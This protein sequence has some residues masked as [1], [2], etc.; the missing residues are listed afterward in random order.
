MLRIAIVGTGIIGLSHIN[1]I[2]SLDNCRLCALCDINED[3]V[4]KLAEE[5]GVP[6]FLNYKDIPGSVEC[7]A[8]IINL[9]HGL[10]CESSIFFLENGIHVLVEKPMANTTEECDKMIEAANKAGKKIAVA[11]VQRYFDTNI[12]LKNIVDSG[13]LGKLAMISEQ[14]SIN[15][16]LDSRP[17]WFL[18]KKAAGGGI[19]M[20]YGAHALDKVQFITGS[21]V[22]EI[23]GS[24]F[25][26]KND[27][28]IEGNAQ[29]F[30]KL[31]NGITCVGTFSGYSAVTYENYYY[32]TG[33]A[34]RLRGNNTIEMIKDGDKEWTSIPITSKGAELAREISEFVKYA[35]GE[36]A[37]IPN[38]NYGRSIIA[39]IE[40]VYS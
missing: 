22:K 32:F 28:D 18:S 20:N 38:G 14:R 35:Q 39:A 6:Y 33:G 8:V 40:K 3:V 5:N 16:F 7:D 27:Y 31:E 12:I 21:Y 34:V 17:R 37:N 9:P 2:K 25:N 24:A 13:E 26:I 11:H 10:H 15:Y 23:S 1:A 4:K 19:L 36:E 29:Y 30:A